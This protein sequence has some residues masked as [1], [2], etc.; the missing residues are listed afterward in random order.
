[1]KWVQVVDQV[2]VFSSDVQLQLVLLDKLTRAVLTFGWFLTGML[3]NV[4]P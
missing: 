3:E 4:V 2:L 1:M